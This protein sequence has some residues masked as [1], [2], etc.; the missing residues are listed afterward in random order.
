LPFHIA[1]FFRPTLLEVYGLTATEFGIAQGAY[2]ITA[3]L[4]Y[5]PGGPL[6]D[7]FFEPGSSWRFHS[8]LPR[9]AAFTWRGVQATP[10]PV[11]VFAF[12]D[13]STIGLF[14]APLLRAAREWGGAYE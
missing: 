6:A 11:F 9:Q 12:F 13:V 14:W 1:K 2:G 3:M 7:R 10:G 5:F 4:A 8:G